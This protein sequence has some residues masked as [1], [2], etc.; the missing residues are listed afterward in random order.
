MS[1][2]V[3]WAVSGFSAALTIISGS[4]IEDYQRWRLLTTVL[5]HFTYEEF[6]DPRFVFDRIEQTVLGVAIVVVVTLAW[7]ERAADQ[8]HREMVNALQETRFCL[9]LLYE[10]YIHTI[11]SP[12]SPTSFHDISKEAEAEVGS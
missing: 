8:L 11:P 4:D 5:F 3:A 2:G 7:P 12:T 10:D 6:W 9:V 1:L